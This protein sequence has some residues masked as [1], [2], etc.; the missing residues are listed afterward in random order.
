MS[1]LP[2]VPTL[3][4]AGVAGYEAWAWQGLAVPNGT[5]GAVV[6]RLGREYEALL[7]D[8]SFRKVMIDE[9]GI[10]PLHSTSAEMGAY[11]R[12]EQAKWAKVI[13]QGGI[14]AD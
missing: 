2:D 5:P 7:A 1:V 6:E 12:S 11:I 4:E 9:A 13:R 3:A 10:E 14:T 8:A